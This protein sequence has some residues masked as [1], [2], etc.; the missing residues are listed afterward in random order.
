ME[1]NKSKHRYILIF[2]ILIG[3]GVIVSL[4]GI[5]MG[6]INISLDNIIKIIFGQPIDNKIFASIVKGIRVPRVL[7]TILGGACLSVSGLLMQIFFRNPIVEPYVLGISSGASLIVG[8]LVLGG[9]S[10]GI[11]NVTPLA[12]FFGAFLGAMVVMLVVVFAAKKVKSVTTLL[13]IGI[14]AGFICGA[15]TS[16]LTAFADKERIAGFV[17]W[18]MGS[19]AGFSWEQIKYLYIIGSPFIILTFF[20]SKPLNA[21]LFGENYAISMGLNTKRFRIVIIVIAS[22]LTAVITAFAGPISFVGLAVPH[23]AR[24]IFRTSDNRILIPGVILMGALMTGICDF[25]ARMVMSPVELPLSAVTS[26]IGAPIVVF[27]L[28]RKKNE[29]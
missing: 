17:M 10:M 1:N 8:L 3:I 27:L 13:I 22:I 20:M 24:L 28:T 5:S 25:C 21:L 11:S 9:Y 18:T 4:L 7:A 16:I 19:F 15:V 2:S 26:L 12:L 6:S 29:L 14:M 23:I